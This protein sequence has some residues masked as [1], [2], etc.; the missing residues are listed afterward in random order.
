MRKTIQRLFLFGLFVTLSAQSASA[1][2]V[3]FTLQQVKTG[4]MRVPAEPTIELVA[5]EYTV[6]VPF[7][8]NV[9]Q[10]YT[11]NV[12]YTENVTQKYTVNVPYTETVTGDDGKEKEVQRM[13]NEER[14]RVVPVQ[15]MRTE[16][17]TREV[18]VTKMRTETRTRQ[19]P[20]TRQGSE[21]KTIQFPP[22]NAKFTFVSGESISNEEMK[23]LAA[24]TI[25]VLRLMP[26]TPLT[27]LQRQIL[28]PDLIV[29]TVTPEEKEAKAGDTSEE[30]SD[31]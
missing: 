9:R 24:E 18:P 5:Q 10:T 27:E 30:A 29:M 16:N 25:T 31:K 22:A 28:K 1:Q 20:V 14:E 8:E 4:E 2:Q 21:L 23:E 15:K 7:T 17:R 3:Q 19:V 11:V 26:N 13:R 6:Q 12:P